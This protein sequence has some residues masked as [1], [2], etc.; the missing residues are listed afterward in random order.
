MKTDIKD[1][2]EM[3]AINGTGIG[4]SLTDIDS[5]LRS[6]ILFATLIYTIVKVRHFIKGG[7]S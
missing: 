2:L 7:K 6:L 4:I 5:I 1:T 3:I